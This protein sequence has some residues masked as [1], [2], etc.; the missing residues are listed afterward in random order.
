MGAAVNERDPLMRTAYVAAFAMSN[1]SSTF[2]RIAKPFN[3][4][5]VCENASDN[6]RSP[7]LTELR[8]K[9]LNMWISSNNTDTFPNK[10]ATTPQFRR[11]GL[12]RPL[13]GTTER[14]NGI[15]YDVYLLLT[16]D[17]AKVDAQNKFMGKSFEI[18]PTGIAHV[19][20]ILNEEWAP[21]YPEDKHPRNVGK[22]VEHYSWKKVI[23]N[24][25]G[26]MLGAPTIDHYG[27][28]IVRYVFLSVIS[29]PDTHKSR[30]SQITVP[31]I[32]VG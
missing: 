14:Y 10:S 27:E 16:C 2:G 28:M 4:M 6:V 26:F 29:S 3:P 30:R 31:R 23:T 19:E 15:R 8:V 20:L 25:S 21:D 18:R 24:I 1:Y 9:L 11:A 17:I 32:S 5:L 12:S 22:V 13:G 7:R